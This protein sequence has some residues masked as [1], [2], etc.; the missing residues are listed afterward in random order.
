MSMLADLIGTAAMV[1][2]P[3]FT[4]DLWTV[5]AAAFLG[6]IGGILWTVNARTPSQRLVH[7]G[8]LGRYNAAARLFSWGAMPLAAGLVGLL[9]QW[10]GMHAAF[11]LLADAAAPAA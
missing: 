11:T 1:A 6:G 8:M 4:T 7:P 10:L 5:A 2:A 3:V 9:A